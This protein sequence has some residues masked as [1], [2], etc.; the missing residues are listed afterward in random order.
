MEL[1]GREPEIQRLRLYIDG[2]TQGAGRRCCC[3][4]TPASGS[5]SLLD[6]AADLAAAPGSGYC[7]RPAPSRSRPTSPSPP[8]T[9][10]SARAL[11]SRRT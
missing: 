6:Q 9:N 1:I 7:A 2:I 11:P 4:V 10:S 3:Q 8:C 5:T